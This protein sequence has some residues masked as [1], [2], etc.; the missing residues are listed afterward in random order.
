MV[1]LKDGYVFYQRLNAPESQKNWKNLYQ[2]AM[3]DFSSMESNIK[4]VKYSDIANEL[5]RAGGAEQNKE[6]QLIRDSFGI[7][8]N[9]I[10]L[11]EY[12][13]FIN[14]INELMGL[15]SQ[16]QKLLKKLKTNKG[17]ERS[18]TAASYFDGYLVTAIS[19]RLRR[20]IDTKTA[21]SIIINGDYNKWTQ[22]LTEI[23]DLAIE[24]AIK[25]M[26][27]QKD[28]IDDE[29]TT[30]WSEAILLLQK[31]NNQLNQFKNDIFKRYNLHNV[32]K[33]TFEWQTKRYQEKKKTT[34]GLSTE[35]KKSTKLTERGNRSVS[36]FVQEY[37]VNSIQSIGKGGTLKSN[38]VKT[39]NVYLFSSSLDID[40]DNL[41]QQLNNSITGRSLEENRK[42]IENF[43]VNY[44]D[45]I[46]DGFIIYENVKNYS[47]GDSFEGFSG[48]TKQHLSE[49]PS[50][51]D[52]I[53]LNINGKELVSL[54]YNTI[55]GSIGEGKKDYI[56]EQV[57]LT[58]SAAI[59]NFLFDDWKTIGK[60]GDRAIHIFNLDGVLIPL[61]YLLISMGEA[62]NNIQRS[63]S[64]YF[65]ITFN[66][67]KEIKYF[68]K[69]SGDE[70]I[71]LEE[72]QSIYDYWKWQKQD[73]E[74]NSTFSIKF[75]ANFKSL[76][77][78]LSKT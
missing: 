9:N 37:V 55:S 53:G 58:T 74:K 67:P 23:I 16:Y 69:S 32:I 3:N 7:N 50:I 12:P 51:L 77:K 31:T 18:K 34:R 26:S 68:P 76:I 60:S 70:K 30:I 17:K 40:L 73:V 44:L 42:I 39:D 78:Q 71:E 24:D 59:A 10:S 14:T 62:I 22:K 11:K 75:L 4:K 41:F 65:K 29:E 64:Q 35:V 15:K 72:G 63:P 28:I 2:S 13:K 49:L 20:F 52:N 47:L 25:K 46:S 21:T 54:L 43:Y 36:G 33:N 45:K 1:Y 56:R 57:R 19:E 38:I 5:I 6:R 66:L 27:Q 61:S 8:I 48:E